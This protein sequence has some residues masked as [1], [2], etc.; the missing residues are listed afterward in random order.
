MLPPEARERTFI[1]LG[2]SHY[3]EP[4]KFGLT[5]K[6]FETPL[7]RASVDVSIV[8]RLAARAA[9]G[10]N[11]EDYC[12]AVEHSIEFQVLFLQW[13]YA[14][15][16]RIVPIL[17]GSF[18]QSIYGHGMPE[19]NDGVARVLGELGEIAASESERMAW[20]LGVDMA[21]VGRRYGDRI[22]ARM[23]DISPK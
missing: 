6:P 17:C 15:A 11:V 5:R 10:V 1:I 20:V 22:T 14:P 9:S 12:H 19:D 18:V 3:G 4:E 16:I 13:L 7:G 2:T 8:D 23:T 21:H